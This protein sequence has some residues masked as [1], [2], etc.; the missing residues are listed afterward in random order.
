MSDI[1]LSGI[2]ATGRLHFGNYVGAV[3]NFVDYQKEGNTCL[4]FVA[5][6]H[7]LTTF[8]DPEALRANLV[9]I[10]KGYLAAGLDPERATIYAQSSVPELAELTALLGM[11]QPHGDLLNNPTVQDKIERARQEKQKVSLGLVTY[12]V[13]MA[14]DILGPKASVVPVGEDQIPNVELARRLARIFNNQFGETFTLPRMMQDMVK[15]PGLDGDKMGKSDSDNA[16][17]IDSSME[18]IRSRYAKKGVTDPNRVHLQDPGDP[19]NECRSVYPLH[20]II[21]EGEEET[22]TIAKACMAAEISCTEC[23]GL[24][25]DSI[26]GILEPFQERRRELANQDDYVREV[27]VEGGRKARAMIA[28]TVQEVQERMGV[29]RY[30]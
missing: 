10:V 23:K 8:I 14:A 9:E 27:L 20:E 13:M 6:L 24:L 26:A 30:V 5:D 1:V 15:V 22:R 4:Y 16:I 3:K 29:V 12:P 28:P 2:R 25:C 21:T 17:D 18:V 7:T 11:L 19:Y